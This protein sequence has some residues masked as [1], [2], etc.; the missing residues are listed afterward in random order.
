MKPERHSVRYVAIALI[1]LSAA[2]GYAASPNPQSGNPQSADSSS[3]KSSPDERTLTDGSATSSPEQLTLTKDWFGLGPTLRK[4]GFDWRLEWSQ[5][6]QGMTQGDGDRSWQY[7][8]HV[9]ALVRIDFSKFGFWDGFSVTNQLY[10]NYGDSV[11]GF[12]GT[13]FPVNSALFF[14]DVH[15]PDTVA[16]VALN[17]TQNFGD[18]WSASVGRFNNIDAI[19]YRPVF[20]GGGVDLFW[21]LNP[22]VTSSGLVP[23]GINAASV[24]LKTEA[25]SYS[26]MVYDPVDAYS[27][28]CS[29]RSSRTESA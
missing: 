24:S 28:P 2:Q 12:G 4:A 11:N 29:K 8:G 6:Y 5:F 14:P 25:V 19:R 1:V 22:A 26:L 27:K 21:N 18:R 16:T 10:W 13:L 17:A 9:D 7:G 20:G 3:V 15:D 23:A